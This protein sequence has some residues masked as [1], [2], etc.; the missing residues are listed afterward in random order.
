MKSSRN[1]CGCQRRFVPALEKVA[2]FRLIK[3]LGQQQVYELVYFGAFGSRSIRLRN[4]EF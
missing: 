4:D 1:V 2:F 3:P